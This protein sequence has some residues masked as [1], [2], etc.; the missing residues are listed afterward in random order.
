MRITG[1]LSAGIVAVSCLFAAFACSSKSGDGSKV[2][3][4]A[5]DG[6]GANGSGAANGAAAANGSGADNGSGANGSG[7]SVQLN[8]GG[9]ASESLAGEKG[10]PTGDSTEICDGIDNDGDG[11]IDNVDKNGDGVCDC[12]LIATLGVKGSSGQG[13]VFATWLTARSDT[14]A[15]DLADQTL[16]P[17]LL[18]KYEV[19]VAQDVHKNHA[20]SDAEASALSDWVNKGGGFMTL[21]G[22]SDAGEAHNV[23][24]LLAPFGMSYTDQQILQKTGSTTIPIT[25]WT[26]HPIDLGVTQ[27]GV[28]N[29]YPV[30]GVGTTIATGGGFDVAKVQEVGKGHVFLWG[31]EWITYNSEWNDHPDYQVQQMWLNTIKWLTVAGQCQVTIPPNPPR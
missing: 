1:P 2:A 12:L 31:D 23:N 13:D 27:V 20:Y 29:G 17:E 14:G 21:I 18:D 16:T 15:T 22:Y 10:I 8:L 4:A 9:S 30:Q 25:M 7:G 28:D 11:I 24:K 26:P 19:I 3:G 5:A 6:S